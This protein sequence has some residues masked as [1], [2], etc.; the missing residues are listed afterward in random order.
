MENAEPLQ[1]NLSERSFKLFG[2]FVATEMDVSKCRLNAA[3]S[4]KSRNLVY[5]PTGARQVCEPQVTQCV[6]RQTTHTGF[7]RN[8]PNGLRP[9]P[10]RQRFAM[11]PAR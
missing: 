4:G 3:V 9:H 11:I 8:S 1:I 10:E 5:I 2:Q 7:D 6:G